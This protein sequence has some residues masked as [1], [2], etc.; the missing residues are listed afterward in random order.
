AAEGIDVDAWAARALE[1]GVA[2]R[3]ARDFE[4]HRRS[5]PFLRLGFTS[6]REQEIQEVARRL[7]GALEA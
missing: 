1:R 7:A 2:F 3:P 5:L 4:F 6:L